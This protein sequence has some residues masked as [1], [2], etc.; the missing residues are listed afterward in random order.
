MPRP[1]LAALLALLLAGSAHAAVYIVPTDDELIDAAGAI[2]IATVGEMKPEFAPNG[3]IVTNIDLGVETVL[4]GELDL[5]LTG[6]VTGGSATLRIVQPGGAIGPHA[7]L[8]SG[9]PRFWE[10][11]RTLLF[12]EK[13]NGKWQVWGMQLGKFDFVEHEGQTL[14]V[15][16]ATERDVAAWT[17]DGKPHEERLRLAAGFIAHIVDRVKGTAPRRPDV[18]RANGETTDSSGEGEAEETDYTIEATEIPSE[19]LQSTFPP[20]AYTYGNFRWDAFDK[21][22]SIYF[23]QSGTQ[24]GYDSTGTSQRSLEAW[25]IESGSNISYLY[26]G[27]TNAAFVQDGTNAIVYNSSTDVPS[28]ALAYAK[29]YASDHHFYKNEEF[30]TIVEGDVVMKSDPGVSQKVF[31]EAIT[32]ELGHTLG[33]RHSDEG[34]PSS[35]Q[36]VMKAVLSG[37]YGANLGPWDVEAARTVYTATAT[38]P[39]APLDLAA[40]AHSTT[41]IDL[42]WGTSSGATSYEVERSTSGPTGFTRIAT[43]TT[44]SYS[45][46][47]VSGGRSYIYRVRAVSSGGSSAYS[48]IDHATT[49]FFTDDPLVPGVTVVKAIHLTELR[50]A[51][52]AVR[53]AAG[54]AAY[55]WTDSSPT[56]VPIKAIHINELRTAITQ[57]LTAIG[58]GT[59][60]TDP[61]LTAGMPIKAVH[62]QELRNYTK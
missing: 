2:V 49:I 12:L 29:W 41:R 6:P 58:K 4:K 23:Y 8:V 7:M 20:S 43:V 39:P 18:P 14:A 5:D 44:N 30:Y 51:V 11:N 10:K 36:A 19:T 15:R 35:T 16:W 62:F 59:A 52:N 24:P 25:T 55:A 22:R 47:S 40:T 61:T 17:P 32:H 34:T 28:G 27:T 1:L 9:A 60:F 48:N 46:T 42:V 45:D 13:V 56:G 54:L 57:A 21:G 3:E 33:F 38:A 37:A 50:T 53:A 26:G 31:D